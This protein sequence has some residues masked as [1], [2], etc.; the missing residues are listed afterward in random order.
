MKGGCTPRRPWDEHRANGEWS[1]GLCSWGSRFLL[2]TPTLPHN[3]VLATGT[4]IFENDRTPYGAVARLPW[5][6]LAFAA[7]GR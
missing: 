7:E 3:F 5:P 6:L 2:G 1:A 4:P